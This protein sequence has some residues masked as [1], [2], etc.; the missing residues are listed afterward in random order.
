MQ[1]Q[2]PFPEALLAA[3]E[4]QEISQRQLAKRTRANHGWGS[5]WTI[6]QLALG[7][8]KPTAH[9]IE[10]IA[11]A[12]QMRPEHFAEYRLAKARDKLDPE[13]VGLKRALTNLGE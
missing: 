6:N 3:L 2:K 10:E 8:L 5:I 13:V 11:T 9:A 4:E 7:Q 1:T 12:L